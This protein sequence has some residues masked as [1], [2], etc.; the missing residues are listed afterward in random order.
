MK[1]A[2][3][4]LT[5]W[6]AGCFQAPM[7]QPPPLGSDAGATVDAGE[8]DA[9]PPVRCQT[10]ERY[11]ATY[12]SEL[13]STVVCGGVEC[14]TGQ[15][16]C[17][18]TGRC[19]DAS[20][21]CPVLPTTWPDQPTPQACSTNAQCNETSFCMP[22]DLSCGGASHCQ[23]IELCGFCSAPGSPQCVVCGCDGVTYPSVQHA[24]I[25]GVNTI[26]PGTCG[27]GP[28]A[29]DAQCPSDSFCCPAAGSCTLNAES[30]RCGQGLN[31]VDDSECVVTGHG[32]GPGA[33]TSAF[34]RHAGCGIARGTCTQPS[35]MNC[36]GAVNTVCGCDG[37]SYVNECWATAAG[38]NVAS[39]G[40]CP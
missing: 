12:C 4:V 1:R 9:G 21:S 8:L 17:L 37:V 20:A 31:C 2:A 27:E 36:G 13:P 39:A 14:A 26:G 6:I 5:V 3:V 32:G 10:F 29:T 34:C 16:C 35:P 30:W 40:A 19:V 25:A 33:S 28:C 22:D 23:P 18:T 24:C 15:Q 11:A 7:E 38:I